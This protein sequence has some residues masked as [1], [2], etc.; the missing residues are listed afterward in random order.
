MKAGEI[1][2]VMENYFPLA[3][4]E[5][6]D[7]SGLQIGHRDQDVSKLMI[8][9]DP[10]EAALD[11]AIAQDC[12]MLI[13]HHPYLFHDLTLD[14]DTPIGRFIEKAIKHNIVI[15]A[16]HT[17]LDKVAMNR[18][19]VEALGCTPLGSIDA[20]GITQRGE[21]PEA[22]HLKTLIALIKEKWPVSC[23][24][25]TGNLNQMVQSFVVCGGAG[26]DFMVEAGAQ[27]DVYITGDIKYHQA[28]TAIEQG[29]T[30]IDAGHHVEV[31]MVD[32]LQALLAEKLDL[33]I[34]TYASADYM[35]V[36]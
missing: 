36:V 14:L 3:L 9:L 23:V 18:W 12:Q 15:Y 6:W 22:V 35:E 2:T 29:I 4:Q 25:T 31:I 11:L 7:R 16:A 32:Q 24:K 33:E 28:Q 27:A 30:L 20:A 19:L 1:I 5:E 34:V 8:A 13:T 26:S 10:D 21:L 17:N